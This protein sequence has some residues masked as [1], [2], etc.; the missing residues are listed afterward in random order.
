MKALAAAAALLPVSLAFL[1]FA[2]AQDA[3]DAVFSAMRSEMDRSLS[4][5]S[6]EGSGPPYHLLYRLTDRRTRALSATLGAL[7]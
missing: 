3:D 6:L 1:P 5:L 7:T 4:R 2:H